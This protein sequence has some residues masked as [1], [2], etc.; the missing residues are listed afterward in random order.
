MTKDEIQRALTELDEIDDLLSGQYDSDFTMVDAV[1][2][3]IGECN[4]LRSKIEGAKDAPKV[5]AGQVPPDPFNCGKCGS[6]AGGIQARMFAESA[7]AGRRLVGTCMDEA[8]P[9]RPETWIAEVERTEA[10]S[11]QVVMTLEALDAAIAGARVEGAEW[12]RTHAAATAHVRTYAGGIVSAIERIEPPSDWPTTPNPYAKIAEEFGCPATETAV[13]AIL[14]RDVAALTAARATIARIASALSCEAS[15]EGILDRVRTTTLRRDTAEE[16]MRDVAASL[17]CHATIE[18][19]EAAITAL[20]AEVESLHGSLHEAREMLSRAAKVCPE[21][22]L[23]LTIAG[24]ITRLR[25]DLASARAEIESLRPYRDPICDRCGTHGMVCEV[26]APGFKLGNATCCSCIALA[27]EE[28]CG[29][30][31]SLRPRAF[32]KE[33]RAA[34]EGWYF[35]PKSGANE[36]TPVLIKIASWL[37]SADVPSERKSLADVGASPRDGTATAIHDRVVP[38]DGDIG[39]PSG[40]VPSEAPRVFPNDLRTL[41]LD[42]A[43]HYAGSEYSPGSLI[44][45]VSRVSAWLRSVES[46]ERVREDVRSHFRAYADSEPAPT[47]TV[48]ATLRERARAYVRID[49]APKT[50]NAWAIVRDLANAPIA[51]EWDEAIQDACAFIGSMP[52]PARVRDGSGDLSEVVFTRQAIVGLRAMKRGTR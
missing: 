24:R 16:A 28:L 14:A 2:A 46:D 21:D 23:D 25:S 36:A 4:M 33:L 6:H 1:R 40:N 15:E 7:R 12:M 38:S 44:G 17:G 49:S 39:A 8:C 48:P 5:D 32:P 37:Q 47:E 51:S 52:T 35:S 26:E 41:V 31:E 42:T 20:K 3:L 19:V 11:D 18:A 13:T 9:Y 34:V 45:I 43:K 30:V 29:E 50:E 22:D 10:K 27:Y